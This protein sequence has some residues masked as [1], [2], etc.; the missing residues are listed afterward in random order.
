MA[1]S[2]LKALENT[3]GDGEIAHYAVFLKE[4]EL[5][6]RK[7]QGLI[8]KGLIFIAIFADSEYQ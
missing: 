7:N 2:S 3:V 6:T 1:G 4:S 5:Q 8:G